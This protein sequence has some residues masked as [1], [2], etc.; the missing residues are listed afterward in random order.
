MILLQG[1]LS[2]P[3]LANQAWSNGFTVTVFFQRISGEYYDSIISNGFSPLSS[4]EIRL[5]PW[6]YNGTTDDMQCYASVQV[7]P[8]LE[9][10]FTSRSIS[11]D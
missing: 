11:N 6:T 1:L 8:C 3:G 7:Q 10:R 4:F 9:L 5:A 2:V